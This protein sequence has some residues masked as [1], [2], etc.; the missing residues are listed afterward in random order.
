MV[1]YQNGKIYKMLMPDGY[2]YIGCSCNEL[3]VRK[4]MHKTKSNENKSVNRRL[5]NHMFIN[6]IDW[7]EV[8]MVLVELFP[9]NS[10]GEL[11]LRES[12]ITRD[13][14]NDIFCLNTMFFSKEDGSSIEHA[15]ECDT[16]YRKNNRNK[17]STRMKLY[18][19]ENSD[20]IKKKREIYTANNKE[21]IVEY[22]EKNKERMATHAKIQITCECGFTLAKKNLKR[23]SNSLKHLKWISENPQ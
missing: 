17:I 2:F 6:N 12:E 1:N 21:K 11:L 14:K 22:N 13:Y 3:R 20:S 19:E 23:H 10:K 16:N 5:Y 15:K 8:R 9:C 4:Q 7:G 18:Y